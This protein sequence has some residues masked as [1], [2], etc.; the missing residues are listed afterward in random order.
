MGGGSPSSPP[1][2][3]RGSPL[4]GGGRGLP[5]S[6]GEG[7]C[8]PSWVE[9]GGSPGWGGG[10]EVVSPPGWGAPLVWGSGGAPLLAEMSLPWVLE[11][12]LCG[13]G[14]FVWCSWA[15][16][17]RR[18]K[19]LVWFFKAQVSSLGTNS[20]CCDLRGC[21]FSVV[22]DCT[23]GGLREVAGGHVYSL[24]PQAYHL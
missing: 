22:V 13:D 1:S 9:G 20:S 23:L 8:A 17:R 12:L 19:F 15:E 10:G 5:L 18:K 4:L 3:L 7:G 21:L 11:W 14:C 16:R 6:G 2:P 24:T